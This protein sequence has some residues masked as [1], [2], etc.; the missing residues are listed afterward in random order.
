[1]QVCRSGYL[2]INR[3]IIYTFLN[4]LVSKRPWAE[5]ER[6]NLKDNVLASDL[7]N[8]FNAYKE[9]LDFRAVSLKAQPRTDRGINF[10]KPKDFG[11]SGKA[12]P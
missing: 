4:R 9:H 6:R 3:A 1:M 11:K 7:E 5:I 8:L 12:K 2:I 10:N